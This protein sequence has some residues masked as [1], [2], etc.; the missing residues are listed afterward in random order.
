MKTNEGDT[1]CPPAILVNTR[2]VT[3]CKMD[4]NSNIRPKEVHRMDQIKTGAFLKELRKARNLTQEQLAEKFGVTQRSVSRWENGKNLPDISL[5]IE[6]AD[7]Y[8]VDIREL[9]SG[10]RMSAEMDADLKETLE[11]VADYTEADKAK[12]L[13]KV[14]IC[15]QGL[16]AVSIASMLVYFLSYVFDLVLS[17]FLLI[18]ASGIL[19]INTIMA[20][21]Q[22]KGRLTREKNKKRI[23]IT[24]A[25]WVTIA[26]LLLFFITFVLPGILVR[27]SGASVQ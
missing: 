5:L 4:N 17:P 12:I 3:C 1:K 7:F 2:T 14:Y 13:N 15:G 9:I 26:V 16:M 24:I 21:L 6:L 10:E 25:I 18:L 22:L 19:S 11:M 27:Y 20:G 23:R 8:D